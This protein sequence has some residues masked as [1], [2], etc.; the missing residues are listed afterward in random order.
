MDDNICN[1][2]GKESDKLDINGACPD[3][4]EEFGLDEDEDEEN[5]DES[6]D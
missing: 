2:C 6:E 1:Y 4:V 3:C 5:E